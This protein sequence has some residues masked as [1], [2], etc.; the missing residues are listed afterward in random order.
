MDLLHMLAQKM[1]ASEMGTP[2]ATLN[3]HGCQ[4]LTCKFLLFRLNLFKI[5]S[6]FCW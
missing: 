3:S 6:L 1:A 2:T 4:L 5:L